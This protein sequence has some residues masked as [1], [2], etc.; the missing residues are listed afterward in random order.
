MIYNK[1]STHVVFS[2]VTYIVVT[3]LTKPGY[4]PI[5][6][7]YNTYEY[8]RIIY[9]INYLHNKTNVEIRGRTPGVQE[10][11]MLRDLSDYDFIRVFII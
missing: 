4:R 7:Y 8:H 9:I 3:N 5:L 1:I 11:F 2:M 10:C 6:L